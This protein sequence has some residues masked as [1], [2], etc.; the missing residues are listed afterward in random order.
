MGEAADPV[1]RYM[2]G[3][4]LYGTPASL[5]DEI[6]RLREDMF[7]D[8]LLCAP[9]SHGSFRLFTEKVLPHFL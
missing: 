3:I 4:V 1:D 5:I 2:N 6:E 7:L 9:L 8:Y